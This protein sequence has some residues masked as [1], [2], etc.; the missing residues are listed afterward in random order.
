MVAC[1]ANFEDTVID[2]LISYTNIEVDNASL[3]EMF[4]K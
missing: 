2:E 1:S 3:S 4:T